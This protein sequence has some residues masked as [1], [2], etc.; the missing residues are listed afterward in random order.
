MYY[1]IF[2]GYCNISEHSQFEI[3][4]SKF[5]VKYKSYKKIHTAAIGRPKSKIQFCNV[6]SNHMSQWNPSTDRAGFISLEHQQPF[7]VLL[8]N[9]TLRF[10]K[11]YHDLGINYFVCN[12]LHLYIE[13]L[14]NLDVKSCPSSLAIWNSVYQIKS[15]LLF[16]KTFVK[17]S[18][19]KK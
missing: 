19:Q 3:V 16:C 15:R 8:W 14:K 7:W 2:H 18:L 4:Q 10:Y 12:C 1:H 17:Y 9:N 5:P 11:I 13:S 6:I